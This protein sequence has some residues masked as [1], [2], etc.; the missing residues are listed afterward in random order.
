MKVVGYQPADIV[1]EPDNAS[2]LIVEASLDAASSGAKIVCFPECFLQGYEVDGAF[3]ERFAISLDSALLTRLAESL[4]HVDITVVTGFIERASDT[5]YNSAAV[6]AGGNVAGVYRKANLLTGESRVF[7]PGCESPTFEAHGVKFGINICNDLNF[8]E[9]AANVASSG[10]E[11]LVCPCN[12]MLK[13]ATA[14]KW[15]HR[16]NEIRATRCRESGLWLLSSD[17]TG[18]RGDR[19]SFGPT[20]VISPEGQVVAQAPVNAPG[21]VTYEIPVG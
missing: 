13:E 3:A 20:A 12:N 15:K 9:C 10:A 14:E 16:H 11:L 5:F 18:A 19:I 17:V 2:A 6:L 4:A 21:Y 1:G 8:T 7:A